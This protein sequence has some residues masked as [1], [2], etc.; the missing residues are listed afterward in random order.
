MWAE[1]SPCAE[2]LATGAVAE[3]AEGS[4]AAGIAVIIQAVITTRYSPDTNAWLVDSSNTEPALTFGVWEV[5][6]VTGRVTPLDDVARSV[7]MPSVTCSV[8]SAT[9]ATALTPPIFIMPAPPPTPGPS[10]TPE[11]RVTSAEEAALR[12][13]I[14][15][16]NCYDHFPESSSFQAFQDTP[17][18]WT[19]EGKS[20]ITHYGLWLVDA[21]TEAITP[22]DELAIQAQERCATTA[23]LPAVVSGKQAQLRVWIALYDCYPMPV[24]GESDIPIPAAEYFASFQESPERWVVEGKAEV[25]RVVEVEVTEQGKTETFVEGAAPLTY[26]GLWE[27]ATGTGAITARDKLARDILA[28][29]CFNPL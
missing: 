6:D 12:V 25:D 22:I 28:L 15:V 21:L 27:V 23:T 9:L 24:E 19:V 13:W 10:P 3:G 17:K 7:V 8:P 11:P 2:Q 29:S 4:V 26:Y 1:I 20:T 16:Y 5:N 18:R 14:S